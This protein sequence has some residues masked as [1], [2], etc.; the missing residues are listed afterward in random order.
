MR[1]AIPVYLLLVS[2]LSACGGS[3]APTSPTPSLSGR[4]QGTITSPTD[5]AG[6]VTLQLTQTGLDVAGPVRLSQD[7]LSDVSGTLTGTLG[8]ASSSTTLQF[9]VTYEYGFGCQGTFSG[10][11]A[12][13]S[14]EMA[15][16]YNGRNCVHEFAG[17]LHAIKSV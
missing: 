2:T 1:S 15:G 4:W 16:P 11:I 3:G 8:T 6:T 10:T 12:I 5:G 9:T 17:T 7:G 13:T 14:G